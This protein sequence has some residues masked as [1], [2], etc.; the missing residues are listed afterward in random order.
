VSPIS[1]A[2][3]RSKHSSERFALHT[4][5]VNGRR[6]TV[7]LEPVI[8]DTLT[9]IAIDQELSI[10]NI[11]STIDRNRSASSLTSA[12]RA[13]VVTYLVAQSPSDALPRHLFHRR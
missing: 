5:V 2:G 13:Y 6:T 3:E 8:W 10:S 1:L 9:N 7:R 11:V 12:I 4:L